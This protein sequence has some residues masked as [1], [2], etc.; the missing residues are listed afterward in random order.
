[1]IFTSVSVSNKI[2]IN[3]ESDTVKIFS[4]IIKFNSESIFILC[5][6]SVKSISRF[7]EAVINETEILLRFF[8]NLIHLFNII[9]LLIT[10]I[11]NNIELISV[12]CRSFYEF[13]FNIILIFYLLLTECITVI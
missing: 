2:H 7:L 12:I 9:T 10:V 8:N 6:D 1:M 3:T 5:S 11:V 4:F 13:K